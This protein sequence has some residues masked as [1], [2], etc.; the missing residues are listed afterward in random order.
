MKRTMI[1]EFKSKRFDLKGPQN[2][3][4]PTQASYLKISLFQIRAREVNFSA[5]TPPF[6]TKRSDSLLISSAYWDYVHLNVAKHKN[7]QHF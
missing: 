4:K 3:Y 6:S 1:D 7:K 5:S 2:S